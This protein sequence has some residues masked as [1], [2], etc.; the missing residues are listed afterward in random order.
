M[1]TSNNTPLNTN[2]DE[3]I[4]IKTEPN[5]ADELYSDGEISNMVDTNSIECFTES[6]FFV[7][8]CFKSKQKCTLLI[9]KL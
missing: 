5:Q 8:I 2:E 7:Y 1:I 3:M 6:R 9:K 4:E